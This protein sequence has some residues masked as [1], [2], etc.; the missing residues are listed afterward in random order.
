[1][2]LGWVAG[3]AA[4]LVW[5]CGDD[6][7]DGPPPQGWRW[8]GGASGLCCDGS[9]GVRRRR[10]RRR[11]GSRGAVQA[12]PVGP[13]RRRVPVLARAPAVAPGRRGRRGRQQR[14]R[15]CRRRERRR[16]GR[17]AVRRPCWKTRAPRA[18]SAIRFLRTAPRML[19]KNG[20]DFVEGPV[21]IASQGALLFSDMHMGQ[22]AGS[23]P[24]STIVRYTPPD[25]FGRSSSRPARNGLA[26]TPDGQ[27][28]RLHARP[29][30]AVAASTS[31][32]ARAPPRARPTGQ[33]LQLAERR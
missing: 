27:A 5:G 4:L 21:W 1:M 7:G 32:R 6:A 11:R 8:R 9:R 14:Q 20:F 15:W 31:R 10:C 17:A 33:A 13:A 30:D 12:A 28:A 19:V 25:T 3:V 29:A 16:S 26:L 22:A 24:P 23:W 2:G 18:R